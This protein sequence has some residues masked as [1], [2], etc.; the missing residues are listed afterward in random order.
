M[1]DLVAA[2]E[3]Q[4]GLADTNGDLN[5]E[6]ANALDRYLGRLYGNEQEGR[7]KVVMR[8]VADTIEWIKPS[9]MKVFASGDEV[10]KFEPVGPEDEEQAQQETDYC[11]HVLMQKNNGFI[12]LHDWFHDALLQ[13]TGYTLTQ[14]ETEKFPKKESYVG[15]SDD[16]LALVTQDPEVEVL[17]YSMEPTEYGPKHS[18]TV[19]CMK[20]Y[21]CTKVTNIPPER[22][23]IAVDW[24]NVSLAGC[25]FVEV[26]DFPTISD[27]RQRGFDVDDEINDGGTNTED[28]WQ[29]ERRSVQTDIYSDRQDLESDPSMRRV[30]TRYVWIRFDE[31]GDGIAELR[32]VIIVGTTILHN[33]ETD[34]LPVAALTPLR[35][36]HEHYGQSIADIVMDLQEIRTTLTRGFL[37]NMYLANNGRY[38]IDAN[39]VNLDDMLVSRPGGV[40]RMNGSVPGSIVPL[41]HPQEGG[42]ILQ[43]IEYVDTIRENRTGVTKYNQGLNADSLNKTATGITQIMTAA[44]QRIELIA[45]VFAETGVKD[46]M[47]IIHGMS[48]KHGRKEEMMKLRNKWVPVNPRTWNER[49]DVTVSVGLGTGNKDQMLQHLMMILQAQQQAIQIGVASP[50]NIYNALSKL[51]QNAGFKQAEEFWTDPEK[52]PPPQAPNPEAIKAQAE[53]Q[54]SQFEA[55][56]DAQKFQAEAMLEQQKAQAEAMEKEKDRQLQLEIARMSEATKLA[57]A[58]K[59]IERQR[60]AEYN[61]QTFEVQKMGASQDFEMKKSGAVPKEEVEAKDDG[62]RELLSNLQSA[63]AMLND[64][65]N[66][67]RVAVRDPKTG[68]PMYGRPMTDEEM[69]AARQ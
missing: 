40:V 9:L 28:E 34:I 41:V 4:E 37:D 33:E 27:L 10:V 52:N 48:I 43:A 2:I 1:K 25:P 23:K 53:M 67:P 58:E 50:K 63:L 44:Q 30:R 24:P 61:G 32:Y 18:V 17:E 29:E 35:M 59:N 45:R 38:A 57:I 20:E 42:A 3:Y 26:I 64:S 46:L 60:E 55:Q 11:N 14:Y 5:E 31:D 47:L 68:K 65:I 21:G 15:L 54:K 13:K 66:R 8:D 36:P 51:T 69:A 19:K 12:V 49:R 16:E 62:M 22:V 7:S 6:R 39:V 56:Q